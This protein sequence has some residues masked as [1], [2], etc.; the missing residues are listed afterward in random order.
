MGK[1]AGANAAGDEKLYKKTT[2]AVTFT[3]MK[4][5]IFSIGDIGKTEGKSYKT[6]EFCDEENLVYKKLY[7]LNGRFCGGIL[8]GD[9]KSQK[10]IFAAFEGKLPID[11]M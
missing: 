3:G 10:E 2:P 11:K 5:S 9:T 4:T 8:I 7:F 1:V 6:K